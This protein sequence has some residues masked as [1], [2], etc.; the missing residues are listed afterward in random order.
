[1]VGSAKTT[2]LRLLLLPLLLVHCGG[3]NSSAGSDL[4]S[5][6]VF[7]EDPLLSVSTGGRLFYVHLQRRRRRSPDLFP[8]A[9]NHCNFEGPVI[10]PGT[11]ALGR[12]V[13]TACP[14][15][16]IHA[17]LITAS[18]EVVSVAPAENGD[19]NEYQ[20]WRGDA[21][22]KRLGRW[23]IRRNRR[24]RAVP[25]GRV[26]ELAVFMD[27][28]LR[29]AV[30]SKA[31]LE[32]R[33]SAI[34]EQVQLVLAYRSLETPV[35][36]SVVRVELVDKKTG[37]SPSSGDIDRY[38]DNFCGWQ[39]GRRQRAAPSSWDHALMLSGLDLVK[40]NNTRVLGLA[41]VNGMCR[42][43]YSCTLSE[44]RSLE[45]ALVVAHELGH[46]LGMKHDGRPD[47]TCHPDRF[48]MSA[49]TGA[50]KT[51]WSRCSNLYLDDFLGKSTAGCLASQSVSSESVLDFGG[52]L[53][54]ETFPADAQCRLALGP[55][56]KAYTS[57]QSPFNNVCKELW[58]LEGS[59]A[60]PAH[61]ALDGT[62]CADEKHCREGA[63][64][65]VATQG[66]SNASNRNRTSTTANP[67][68]TRRTGGGASRRPPNRNILWNNF[69]NRLGQLF[70]L[71]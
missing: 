70:N 41:W 61:P 22:D 65:P 38:L 6:R 44:A 46:A 64:I 43:R 57:R 2:L 1:M 37:P 39:C 8:G 15:S 9:P 21:S 25:S 12:A 33:V 49:K 52:Q 67:T 68:S 24:T 63:C 59:W 34:L 3:T 53:P 30:P 40:G 55:K 56:F 60:S 19:K 42:C 18:G 23:R 10:E 20:V 14:G 50:G 5:V 71:G 69:W 17:L 13:V 66:L 27:G 31:A 4:E 26:I 11:R 7:L 58:C 16:E 28:A 36:L 62:V 45:A 54:G 29:E 48:L 32:A 35:R 51:N 47:N